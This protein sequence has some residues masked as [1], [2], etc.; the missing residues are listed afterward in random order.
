MMWASPPTSLELDVGF[1][2]VWLTRIDLSDEEIKKYVE[3]LSEDEKV[4][5][6]KFSVPYKYDEYVVSRG[7]LRKALS[8]VLKQD[9]LDFQFE[10]TESNKPY[11]SQKNINGSIAF[12][13]SHSH[14]RALIAI[15]VDRNMGIDIEKIRP[16]VEYEKLAGRFFSEAEYA[17]LMLLPS[18]ERIKAFFATWTR[19]EAFVKAVGKGIAFGLSE[20]DVNVDAHAQ[21]LMLA[22][23][24]NPADVSTWL[25]TNI[26]VEDNYCACIATD[27]G[28]FQL[29]YWA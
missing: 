24:W 6:A 18:A 20:F 25:M 12:N 28:E 26:D 29:R 23:R 21:P 19:K 22:T 16:E 15:S 13:L 2:D 9:P 17:A 1:I 4:R 8:H 14:G 27:G 3:T 10:Y 7:L 11:L 5:A